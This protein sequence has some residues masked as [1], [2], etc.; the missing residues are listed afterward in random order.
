MGLVEIIQLLALFT[1]AIILGNWFLS[2]T[3]KA[4]V[5]RAPWYQPYLSP[6][7]ILIVLI[8]ILLPILSWWFQ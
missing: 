4:K 1:A 5:Q 8:V 2:E 6:P 7:G 3:K